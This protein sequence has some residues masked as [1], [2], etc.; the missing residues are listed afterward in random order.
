MVRT[1]GAHPFFA[2]L[3]AALIA[4]DLSEITM[5]PCWG[6]TCLLRFD[7]KNDYASV[8]SDSTSAKAIGKILSFPSWATA[9]SKTPPWVPSMEI[10]FLQ[11]LNASM[12][13]GND[14]KALSNNQSSGQE[15]LTS[16]L[17]SASRQPECSTGI[18]PP[19]ACTG[20]DTP[21]YPI[22]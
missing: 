16:I 15:S 19:R 1:R 9:I 11:C 4:L 12:H 10:K 6:V 13:E 18:H 8:V 2:L 7:R 20:N 5:R 22:R 3:R 14:Q 17:G 21:F